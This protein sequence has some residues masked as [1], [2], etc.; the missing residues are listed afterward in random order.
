MDVIAAVG[1]LVMVSIVLVV[2]VTLFQNKSVAE[3][4]TVVI[5]KED[6]HRYPSHGH[7]HG[8]GHIGPY[9]GRHGYHG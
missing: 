1:V 5:V 3:P 7:G 9:G 6:R 4:R 2:Y 8:H